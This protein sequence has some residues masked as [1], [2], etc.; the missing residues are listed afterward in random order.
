MNGAASRT[1]STTYYRAQRLIA[2]RRDQGQCVWC[3]KHPHLKRCIPAGC[4]LCFEAD[5]LTHYSNGG[6]DHHSNL[7]T[8]CR[9]CNQ[10]RGT[11]P[12]PPTHTTQANAAQ[13]AMTASGPDRTPMAGVRRQW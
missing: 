4:D 13:F 11:H 5:H 9:G 7:L 8:S 3:G 12:T 6:S 2:W 10:A 1:G